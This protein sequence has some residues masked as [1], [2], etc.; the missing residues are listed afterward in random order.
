MRDETI[1]AIKIR[2]LE[3][4]QEKEVV[5]STIKKEITMKI[6][7]FDGI[8]SLCNG[9]VRFIIRHDPKAQFYFASLQS[10]VG[11]TL[12]KQAGLPHKGITSVV[13]LPDERYYL[14]SS[15][16]LHILRDM[17]GGWQL[18]YGFI[19]VPRFI[20]DTVYRLF[21]FARYRIGGKQ[22]ACQIPTPEI[23]SRFL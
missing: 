5:I 4:L 22:K 20:R 12:L 2:T 3:M 7:L 14:R 23:R 15:A 17:D 11:Q 19:I 9:A 13:Y 6:I 16:I 1:E 18:L 10:D 8:C 21:A